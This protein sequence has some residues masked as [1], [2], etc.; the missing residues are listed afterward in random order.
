MSNPAGVPPAPLTRA[1][2]EN[3]LSSPRAGRYLEAADDDLDIAIALYDWNSRVA[4][5]AFT[6][7]GH[8]EVALRNAYDRQM[9]GAVADWS[10]DPNLRLLGLVGG[11]PTSHERQRALNEESQKLVRAARSGL[12]AVPV[13]GRVIAALTFGFWTKLTDP[14]REPTYW[15]HMLNAAFP[16]GTSRGRIH[17]QVIRLNR[18]RNRLAHNEPVF[19]ST[20][21]LADRLL[22]LNR[23]LGCVDPIA[24]RWIAAH[25]T[26]ASVVSTCPVPGLVKLPSR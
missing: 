12:G 13:H 10:L 26:V 15:T 23:L 6:D 18:F 4:A 5:A 19:S 3:W 8:A 9:S 11:H 14:K 22:D 7:S 25:S 17:D 20:T 16:S 21:G 24:G 1:Q 2:F